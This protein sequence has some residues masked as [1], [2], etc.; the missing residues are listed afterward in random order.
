VTD[1]NISTCEAI[2]KQLDSYF[3]PEAPS[4]ARE[5]ITRHLAACPR[6]AEFTE[7]R[8]RAKELLQGAVRRQV[9][10]PHLEAKIRRRLR[11]PERRGFSVWHWAPAAGL[12]AAMLLLFLSGPLG[13]RG[14]NDPQEM[15]RAAQEQYIESLSARVV[16]IMRVGLG[17][18]LHCAHFRK[19]PQDAPSS[20]EMAAK[21]GPEYAALIPAV[22]EAVP[23]GHRMVM[24]H[25]CKYRGRQ[26]VHMVVRGDNRLLSLVVARKQPGE[27][28]ASPELAA[29]RNAAG[30]P[31]YGATA[32]RFEVAAFEAGDHLAFVVSDMAQHE[33]L[34]WAANVAPAVQQLL[35][36]VRG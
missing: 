15:D 33:H 8:R 28:L 35:M 11:E 30:I 23:S 17:D 19:F 9:T 12:V 13:W 31:I 32:D 26:F 34:A 22:R 21:M 27:S 6:C 20:E 14:Q 1:F 29:I 25:Q 36:G 18:H 24:A 2:Q 3:D 10:P 5:D 16:A 7:A 4:S